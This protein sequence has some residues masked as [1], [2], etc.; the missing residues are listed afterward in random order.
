MEELIQDP[1]KVHI[2]GFNEKHIYT[3]TTYVFIGPVPKNISTEAKNIAKSPKHRKESAILKKYYGPTWRN[4]LNL[5]IIKIGGDDGSNTV[6]PAVREDHGEFEIDIGEID[7]KDLEKIDQLEQGQSET[8]DVDL[9]DDSEKILEIP[10][11]KTDAEEIRQSEVEAE[12]KT[13]IIEEANEESRESGESKEIEPPIKP[14]NPLREINP[15]D[16]NPTKKPEE[17]DILGDNIMETVETVDIFRDTKSEQVEENTS[18]RTVIVDYITIYPE[19]RISEIKEKIFLV[20]KILPYRQHLFY[21]HQNMI[22]TLSYQLVLRESRIIVDIRELYSYTDDL[23]NIPI[24]QY[25]H[26]NRDDLRVLGLDY[27]KTI[28][29]LYGRH[30]QSILYLFDLN[31][32]INPIRNKLQQAF[33]DKYQMDM[34]Y[35]GFIVK[36]W[37][38]ITY[39]AWPDYLKSVDFGV[40]Y[41]ELVPS[42]NTLINKYRAE[43]Q[44]LDALYGLDIRQI[45][46]E[47]YK[48]AITSAILNVDINRFGTSKMKLNIRN[49]FDRLVLNETASHAKVLLNKDGRNIVLHKSYKGQQRKYK[50]TYINSILIFIVINS[51][52]TDK[53]VILQLYD[54]G[55]YQIRTTWGE[56][57]EMDFEAIHQTVHKYVNPIIDHI[58]DMGL[59]VFNSEVR[60]RKPERHLIQYTGL[61]MNI[62]W[63]RLITTSDFKILRNAISPH[64]RAGLFQSRPTVVSNVWEY[65]FTKGITEYDIRNIERTHDLENYY[66]YMTDARVKQRWDYLFRKGR[67]MKFVH[68]TSDIK[69]EIQGVREREFDI[70]HDYIIRFMYLTERQFSKPNKERTDKKKLSALKEQDPEAYDFRRHDSSVVYSRLCQHKDQ[71]VMYS[72]EEYTKMPEEKKQTLFEYWNFTRQ[73]K[74]YFACPDSKKPHISFIVGKHPKNYCLVCCKIT[75]SD[76]DQVRNKNIRKAQIYTSCRDEHVYTGKKTVKQKSKYIM[77]YGKDIDAGRIGQLPDETMAPLFKDTLFNTSLLVDVDNINIEF[78]NIRGYYLYGTPQYTNTISGIGAIFTIAH[79][80]E[81]EFDVFINECIHR[82][83]KGGFRILLGGILPDYFEDKQDLIKNISYTFL[84]PTIKL[85]PRDEDGMFTMWNELFIDMTKL[86]FQTIIL[87]FE[88]I[89]DDVEFIIPQNVKRTQ[90][91]IPTASEYRFIIMLKKDKLYYP[92]YVMEPDK[93]FNSG[94]IECRR[95]KYTD[96]IILK[97]GNLVTYSLGQEEKTH[98]FIDMTIIQDFLKEYPK[99]K[100]KTQYVTSQNLVYGIML[101]GPDGNVYIPVEFSYYSMIDIP[102]EN[103]FLRSKQTLTWGAL[104]RYVKT[105]NKFVLNESEKRNMYTSEYMA[106]SP[107]EQK[108]MTQERRL[109]PIYPLIKPEHYL[110]VGNKIIG[111][112]SNNLGYY[113]TSGKPI[114]SKGSKESKESNVLQLRYDPDKVNQ[115]ILS[116]PEPRVDRRL[117]TLG[118]SL[119]ENYIYQI[120]V[121]EFMKEF[122]R[123]KN[124]KLRGE[125]IKLIK[126]T[127]FKSALI[128]F[129]QKFN[130]ILEKYPEDAQRIKSQINEFYNVHMDKSILIDQINGSYYQFDRLILEKDPAKLRKQLRKVADKFVRIGQPRIGDFPNILVPCSDSDASYC[131]RNRLIITADKLKEIIDIFS[132]LIQDPYMERYLNYVTFVNN[133]LDYF[134]FEKRTHESI[135]VQVL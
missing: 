52:D 78:G 53:Y 35:Y 69:V 12:M 86:Y 109:I 125:L 2:M 96:G 105:F 133:T 17:A 100:I 90:E 118:K 114:I 68:R 40:L 59:Y 49:L 75:P 55:K 121:M 24:D 36:Y 128:G 15:N 95:F 44:I 66:Q 107:S 63:K 62:Y 26:K 131:I 31:D 123:Q 85:K 130:Q 122:N 27:F 3:K 28:G 76:P 77:T 74:A 9:F 132:S 80:M 93:F 19:D 38:M 98:S 34:F 29:N 92:I 79:A 41:P 64:V 58:N 89:Y 110:K 46:P 51:L 111:F 73:E 4:K 127:N 43:S 60:L 134:Q 25:T 83:K 97:I 120:V 94:H 5:N 47:R 70:V 54:N 135:S 102:I 14:D 88:D 113:I 116:N 106:L 91:L 23:Y 10:I 81:M 39:D 37:P 8:S 101:D 48:L 22:Y 33:K 20:T 87:M 21:E 1:I 30:G 119:Y 7:I 84:D 115:T 72:I 71:P 65:Y 108:K 42:Y 103:I 117:Q 61:N 16:Q 56:E 6:D 18:G 126:E 57:L 67:L 45:N 99:Y 32:F 104:D 13:S 50:L 129:I 11:G 82:L 112:S 124:K